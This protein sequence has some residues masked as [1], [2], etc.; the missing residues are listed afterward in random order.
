MGDKPIALLIYALVGL[1]IAIL[2]PTMG[3]L[4]LFG[5]SYTKPTTATKEPSWIAFFMAALSL[6]ILAGLHSYLPWRYIS[7]GAIFSCTVAILVA[8]GDRIRILSAV[9]LGS[10][11]IAVIPWWLRSEDQHLKISSQQT[12]VMLL[13]TGIS[14]WMLTRGNSPQH[15]DTPNQQRLR[16]LMYMGF[17][18]GTGYLVMSTGLGMTTATTA[19]WHHWGAYVGPAQLVAAGVVPLHDI[20]LQYGLG[21]T[22]L[23]AQTCEV[24]CWTSLYWISGICTLM[25]TSLVAWVALHFNRSKHPLSVLATLII[26]L[27]CCLLWTAYPPRLMAAM[28]TPST[29][30]I[31]FLP[32]ILMLAWLVHQNNKPLAKNS[33]LGHVLWLACILWSP[34]A[35][36]HATALW[37]PYFVWNKTFNKDKVST[38][39]SVIIFLKACLTLAT[40]LIAGLCL[41]ATVF[42]SIYGN[43]PLPQEYAAYVVHP[44]GPMPINTLGTIWFAIACVGCWMSGWILLPKGWMQ[45]KD[46]RASWLV[47]L[48]CLA[49]FTYYLG[50][51]HDN[52]ILNLLPYLALLLFATRAI[53]F[54]G[55]L[56]ALATTL[57]AALLG[58]STTFGVENYEEA[59]KQHRLLA[60]TPQELTNSFNRETNQGLFFIKPQANEMRLKPEDAA[61]ALMYIRNTFNEPVEVFDHFLLVDGGETFNPWNALHGPENFVS[62]PSKNRRIYLERV[63]KRLQKPGWVLYEKKWDIATY[64]SDYDSVYYRDK[65]IIFG[66]YIAI[67]YVPK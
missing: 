7:Y 20:P 54:N 35:G 50:R 29:T 18:I 27:A 11:L 17:A 22:L 63:A 40:V 60:F 34:E 26:V 42:R 44:P 33:V 49:T 31:R 10:L 23:L 15:Q 24:N 66:T 65:E 14:Y 39:S 28:A 57:L 43:W 25:M 59:F 36:A 8:Q 3:K 55:S 41:F 16:S 4:R 38:E 13:A 21:P 9:F 12:I 48:L 5:E 46:A 64:L 52:N 37:A 58:W 6:L 53:T 47:S 62:I 32:G 56:H 1:S 2:M 61:P 45:P 19:V 30:G 51:S 67:R